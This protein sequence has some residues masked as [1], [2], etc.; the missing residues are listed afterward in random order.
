MKTTYTVLALVFVVMRIFTPDLLT[1]ITLWHWWA[2]PM[3]LV[4]LPLII[5]FFEIVERSRES[6]NNLSNYTEEEPKDYPMKEAL[7]RLVDFL[8]DNNWIPVEVMKSEF[9]FSSD[10]ISQLGTR[11]DEWGIT[12]KDKSDNNR[13]KLKT[14]DA[15]EI[16][17]AVHYTAPLENYA[18]V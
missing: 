11:L 6:F 14:T 10:K 7:N 12:Y 15:D 13:R 16:L 2:I 17:T 8:I 3:L 1:T 4:L 9:W 5:Y 18:T